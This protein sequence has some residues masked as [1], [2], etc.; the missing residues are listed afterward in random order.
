MMLSIVRWVRLLVVASSLVSFTAT[1]AYVVDPIEDASARRKKRRKRRGKK[2]H[3]KRRG[4]KAGVKKKKLRKEGSLKPR[5]DLGGPADTDAAKSI[6]KKILPKEIEQKAP[7]LTPDQ[8]RVRRQRAAAGSKL[9][10]EVADC[11]E[12]MEFT[13]PDSPEMAQVLQR[14]ADLY[15]E[16][17][18]ELF[19][20]SED[21]NT[22]DDKRRSCKQKMKSNQ[23]L[24]LKLYDRITKEYKNFSGYDDIL[25]SLGLYK[26]EL[27]RHSKAVK[28]F[29]DI[30]R[31]YPDSERVGDSWFQL[32]EYFFNIENSADKA[33]SG[34]KYAATDKNAFIY[35]FSIYKQGW[36]YINK[37]DWDLALRQFKNTIYLTCGGKGERTWGGLCKD[38]RRDYVRAYSN[39]GDVNRAIEDFKKIGGLK[40]YRKMMDNLGLMYVDQGKHNSLIITYRNLIRDQP[41]HLRTPIFQAYIVDAAGAMG[42]KGNTVTQIAILSKYYKKSHQLAKKLKTKGGDEK[43]LKQI[44]RSL[45]EA[46]EIAENTVR[47]IAIEYDQEGTK[48]KQRQVLTFSRQV[49]KRYLEMFPDSKHVFEMTFLL[50]ELLYKLAEATDND[51]QYANL[52]GE[53]AEVYI[54]IVKMNPN[55]EKKKQK[56]MVE[57]SAGNAVRALSDVVSYQEKMK[58]IK[59]KGNKKVKLSAI[60]Q[61]LIDACLTY[62]KYRPHGDDIVEIRYKMARIYYLF[63]HFERAAPAFNELVK[64][65]PENEVA[66]Y[67]A[68]LTIDIYTGQDDFHNLKRV[69]REYLDNKKLNCT[70]KDRKVFGEIEMK[71]TFKL[72]EHLDKEEKFIEAA[73][74]YLAFHKLFPNSKFTVLSVNNAAVA[75][76]KGNKIKDAIN[77][78]LYMVNK[79]ANHRHAD[80][81]L[82]RDTMYNIAQSYERIVDFSNGAHYLELFVQRYPTDKRAKD[83]IFNAGLYRAVL[84]QYDQSEKNR[85]LYV[86]KYVRR[87][88]KEAA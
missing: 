75:W 6:K 46:T 86:R 40:N 70:N 84:H 43:T 27:E 73:Q 55:P 1:V 9:D 32:G 62:I 29:K 31:Y 71:S 64:N 56:L 72:A 14:C 74:A 77:T 36:C 57:A 41:E 25:Y 30:I 80:K 45:R 83:A 4:G 78:R 87:K 17:S 8:L 76:D 28:H 63:N 2:R 50:A 11:E 61:K 10:E 58:P 12:L 3:K 22:P 69:S 33:L 21:F 7:T 49:Y 42:N 60:Y 20:C 82:I 85:Q 48:R 15:W 38:G 81:A 65:H 79:L 66:C 53:A 51:K 44:E 67:A 39:V 59:I 13:D 52:M 16:K 68:N 23:L 26:V 19:F 35:P 47:R 5:E 54:Q 37:G 88:K 34:Y 24:T 18:K